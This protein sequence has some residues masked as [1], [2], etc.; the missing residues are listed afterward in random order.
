MIE[1]YDPEPL[2][3][4]GGGSGPAQTRPFKH[5]IL[6]IDGTWQAA[7]SDVFHSNVY[8]HNSPNQNFQLFIYSAGL[9]TS[10][11][12]SRFA[13]GAFGEGLDESILQAY[14]NL[15]SNYVPGDK[16]YI[17]GF[18]RGAVAA[19]ALSGFISYSGL[20]KAD[21]ATLIEHAWRY[22]TGKPPLIDYPS[23]RRA[24]THQ[25][26]EIEFLG[27]WDTVSGPYRQSELMQRYRFNNLKLDR[28]VK[29]GVHILSI[30]ESRTDFV[31]IL[32]NG[33]HH[34]AQ[35]LEQI[36]MPGVHGDIGGGYDDA[37][38]STIS[39]LLMIDKLAQ[40]CPRLAFDETY[41]GDTLLPIVDQQDVVVNDEW[42][43]YKAR[44]LKW[45]R[46]TIR[47][48]ENVEGGGFFRH[49]ITDLMSGKRINFKNRQMGY[50]PS[51]RLRGTRPLEEPAFD[52]GSWYRREVS[53]RLRNKF[54]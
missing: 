36:W 11:Q 6:G 31:P 20:L 46:T 13:A 27:V 35:S 50:T 12:S 51:F 44:A 47:V 37:F 25:N 49:P 7:Y 4:G 15:V 10:N 26:V 41:I 18:S 1:K 3:H 53:G 19:R 8:R 21:Y 43:A 45:F 32:W 9:G 33:R 28:G 39:L 2:I 34:D 16:I 30:D 40:Y 14:I 54:R 5:L 22:F 17:F 24:A 42:S 38:L 52:D 23:Q 29:T 48:A